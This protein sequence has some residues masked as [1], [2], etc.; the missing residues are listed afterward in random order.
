VREALT[1]YT[2]ADHQR[3]IALCKAELG[4]VLTH[5]GQVEQ[6]L[7]LTQETLA[8]ARAANMQMVLTLCL[9]YLGVALMAAG[10]LAGAHRALSEAIERAWAHRYF[11]NLMNAFYYVAELSLLESN[12]LDQPAALECQTVVVTA[13]S[14]VRT[15]AAT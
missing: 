8:I 5:M 14:C 10:D 9:N 3:G 6:A 13:F 1:I 11:Y 4:W 2:E 12:T 7:P 15:Q